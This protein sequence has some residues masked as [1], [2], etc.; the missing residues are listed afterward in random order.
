MPSTACRFRFSVVKEEWDES[1]D[2]PVRTLVEV[3]LYEVGP[4]TFPAYEATTAGVRSA[5]AYSAYRATHDD[6]PQRSPGA[7]QRGHTTP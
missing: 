2:T 1:G 6:P 7:G 3:R 5:E 4:V